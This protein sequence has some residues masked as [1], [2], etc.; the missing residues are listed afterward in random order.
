MNRQVKLKAFSFFHLNLAYSAI[1]VERRKEV[2]EKCYWPL[3][4]LARAHNLPFGIEASAWTLETIAEIDPSWLEELRHLVTHGPCEFIGCG[5]AQVIG[6]LVPA[7][8]NEANFRIGMQRYKELLGL[9]PTI[10]LVNEQAY[11]AGLVQLYKEAGYEALIM[12]W[13]NPARSHPEWNSEWLYYP[14]YAIGT[15]GSKISLIW[16]ESISFQKVQRFVH[17]DIE[18]SELMDYYGKHKGTRVR[19]FP[20]YGNDVEVFDFRPGRYMTEAII[21][22]K[23]W[24][25][26][27][28][29]YRTLLCDPDI[30]MVS[31]SSVL[32]MHEEEKSWQQLKLE[33]AAYPIPVKKQDKYNALRWAVTGR[34]DLGINTAC[35]NIFESLKNT[36]GNAC[37]EDWKTLCYLWSSDF[38]T[39]ITES[40]WLEYRSEL[41]RLLQMCDSTPSKID[42]TYVTEQG[43]VSGTS[44]SKMR[45][46]RRGRFLDIEGARLSISF[47]CRRGMAVE[48]FADKEVCQKSL[49]GTLHHGAFKE[50]DLGADYYSGHLV[51][52]SPGRQKITDLVGLEPEIRFQNGKLVIS[53][54]ISTALGNIEKKWVVNDGDGSICLSYVINWHSMPLGALRVGFVTVN[55]DSFNVDELEYQTHNGGAVEIYKM[56]DQEFSHADSVSMLVSANQCLG[57]TEG[58]FLIGDS[59]KKVKIQINK[60]RS[61]GVGLVSHVRKGSSHLTRFATSLREIDDTSK[62]DANGPIEFELVIKATKTSHTA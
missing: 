16:N 47:N 15:E 32:G 51:L 58:E 10:A 28:A 59:E 14:Q 62:G 22:T 46:T 33:S 37:E 34:D 43:A 30:E 29:L 35:W 18:L 3:L 55:P 41:S 11:S 2:V 27:D 56:G 53:G 38:R 8:V 57:L 26:M 7:K 1:G 31:P 40:R 54:T 20:I 13:N 9:K 23:E 60:L 25:R 24:E 49:F 42:A 12:E 48:K 61:A 44:E 5:Y 50:I 45:W 19:A 21:E 17:G 36:L 52:E 6:P 4:R 39:H